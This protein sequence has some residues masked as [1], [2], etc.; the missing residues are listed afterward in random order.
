MNKN[1][2]D[3]SLIFQ[4][5]S[6]GEHTEVELSQLRQTLLS[7]DNRQ[8]SLQLGKFN[9]NIGDGKEIHIGDRIY[10]QWNDEAIE[11]LV[12]AIQE[13]NTVHQNTQGGDAAA[14]DIH[15]GNTYQNCTFIQ[16]LTQDSN[17]CHSSQADFSDLDFSSIPNECIQQAYQN[18]LP[19][20]AGLWGWEVDD[21]PQMLET[22]K[23]FRRLEQFFEQLSQN[24]NISQEI[25]NKCQDL[26]KTFASKKSK[27][28]HLKPGVNTVYSRHNQQLE[29]Y[30]IATLIPENDENEMFLLNAWLIM[31]NSIQDLSKYQSLLDENE[32]QQGVLCQLNRVSGKFEMFLEKALR[33]LRGKRY[34]LTIEFFLPSDLMC[35]EVDRWK[36]SDPI[37]EDICLG[38]MYPIRLRSWERLNL[39]YLDRYLSQWYDCWDRLNSIIEEIVTKDSVEE[40]KKIDNFNREDLR[41]KLNQKN[42]LKVTVAHPK[43]KRKDLFRAILQAAIPIA[44]WI[45]NDISQIDSVKEID[46][47]LTFKPLRYLCES[48]KKIRADADAQ[49]EDHLGLHL[50]LLWENPYRLT[51]NIMVELRAPG[52]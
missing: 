17:F 9:V 28:S 50:A 52:Q 34:N 37:D 51:P 48:I 39:K 6:E 32:P 49:T 3:L 18:A 2:F 10:Q 8:F 36:I 43:S 4:K 7:A 14:R 46:K 31:D 13:T 5:I 44:I 33:Y 30:L 29:S 27:K 12:K 25:R 26:A 19:A 40:L 42:G 47:V 24:K 15:K 1:N 22:L 38:I 20:D 11:A 16:L 21:L 35:L 45:R 23:Q 41:N